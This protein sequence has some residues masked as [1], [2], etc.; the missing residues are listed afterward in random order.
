MIAREELFTS[1]NYDI[2]VWLHGTAKVQINALSTI[3][4]RR[5]GADYM[6]IIPPE[7]CRAAS[8]LSPSIMNGCGSE[9]F[10]FD[11]ETG[12]VFKHLI[13]G[14]QD[15]TY[16]VNVNTGGNKATEEET[17]V[18]KKVFRVPK[19]FLARVT[20]PMTKWDDPIESEVKVLLED[21]SEG[22]HFRIPRK[23]LAPEPELLTNPK[24]ASAKTEKGIE[25]VTKTKNIRIPSTHLD[26]RP[27]LFQDIEKEF[28]TTLKESELPYFP[29]SDPL[30]LLMK[31]TKGID[32]K[33]DSADHKIGR[34]VCNTVPETCGN[35]ADLTGDDNCVLELSESKVNAFWEGRSSVIKKAGGQVAQN[36]DSRVNEKEEDEITVG[37]SVYMNE[38]R[39]E[40]FTL[41]EHRRGA[42]VDSN[43]T[44][45]KER[46]VDVSDGEIRVEDTDE[47]IK[48]QQ[49]LVSFMLP[50][51]EVSI[52][53]PPTLV[54]LYSFLT[55]SAFSCVSR[56]SAL[57]TSFSSI[58]SQLKKV[59]G[60]KLLILP[61]L[62]VFPFLTM[63]AC[64]LADYTPA[65]EVSPRRPTERFGLA[66]SPKESGLQHLAFLSGG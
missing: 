29:F 42:P 7:K 24:I 31:F 32:P 30:M 59:E 9:E 18:K 21:K 38:S 1:V 33:W 5:C 20:D 49:P 60:L 17:T 65:R 58:G 66:V 26:F 2:K 4:P 16:N 10:R 36:L 64:S 63:L 25:E 6:D 43:N 34:I 50:S 27:G 51:V 8:Y 48:K 37:K 12:E 40:R 55:L 56:A 57:M 54:S 53:V 15:P 3:R 19:K 61:L 23:F 13:V 45:L 46:T 28:E 62:I 22:K 41:S 11:S 35:T 44:W 39:E 14:R 52:A 47:M